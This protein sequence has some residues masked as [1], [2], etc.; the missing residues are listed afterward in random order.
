[1]S[2]FSTAD[3]YVDAV[4]GEYD[5]VYEWQVQGAVFLSRLYDDTTDAILDDSFERCHRAIYSP[6]I[7]DRIE[8]DDQLRSRRAYR[9]GHPTRKYD[10]R[11][12]DALDEMPAGVEQAVMIEQHLDGDLMWDVICRIP[13]VK[14][15]GSGDAVDMEATRSEF[16]TITDEYPL[17]DVGTDWKYLPD[18]A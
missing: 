10:A 2:G 12:K 1:M 9:N 15:T 11:S 13:S 8:E 7:R 3:R 5:G 6:L 16:Q 14:D 17:E 18:T 4:L